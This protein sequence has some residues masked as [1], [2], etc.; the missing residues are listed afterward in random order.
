MERRRFPSGVAGPET[1]VFTAGDGSA[2][3]PN[4]RTNELNNGLIHNIIYNI[5]ETTDEEV[6]ANLSASKA[7]QGAAFCFYLQLSTGT[8]LKAT[9]AELGVSVSS[10]V[11]GICSRWLQLRSKAKEPDDKTRKQQAPPSNDNPPAD[12]YLADLKTEW[13]QLSPE[14]K[15]KHQAYVVRTYGPLGQSFLAQVGDSP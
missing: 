14:Q 10:L 11:N 2:E 9:A 8:S 12:K 13:P 3:R 15:A 4:E 1:V 5:P 6:T 7:R